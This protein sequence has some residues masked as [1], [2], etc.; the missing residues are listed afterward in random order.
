MASAVRQCICLAF[1][2]CKTLSFPCG[3]Q[4]RSARILARAVYQLGG[5]S[6]GATQCRPALSIPPGSESLRASFRSLTFHCLSAAF[7]LHHHCRSLP[8]TA[9]P[10]PF[11]CLSAAFL[12]LLLPFT[13]FQETT[14]TGGMPGTTVCRRP[15]A[16]CLP[17]VVQPPETIPYF[18]TFSTA[19]IPDADHTRLHLERYA[20]R[21]D[22]LRHGAGAAVGPG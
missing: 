4:A 8:F 22:R 17:P 20:S 21:S 19:G 13:A 12:N 3:H 11:H 9:L 10:L 18:I 2:L 15:A 1:A 16:Q 14:H 5:A 6:T 7:P